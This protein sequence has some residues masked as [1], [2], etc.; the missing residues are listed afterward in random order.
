MTSVM[1]ETLTSNAATSRIGKLRPA[2]VPTKQM[3][4]IITAIA[5]L[6]SEL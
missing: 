2:T 3:T 5:T 4:T 6:G 1:A